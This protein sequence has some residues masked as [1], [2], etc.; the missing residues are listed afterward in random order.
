MVS[1]EKPYVAV[2]CSTSR[3]KEASL[4]RAPSDSFHRCGVLLEL[5]LALAAVKR[6]DEKLVVVASRSKLLPVEGPLQA[7]NLLSVTAELTDVTLARAQVSMKDGAVAGPCR[8]D[9][10]VPCDRA[11][12]T[13]VPVVVNQSTALVDIPNLRDTLVGSNSDQRPSSVPIHRSDSV[14]IAYLCQFLDC[15]SLR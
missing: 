13:Q 8:Q 6:R 5:M 15:S 10:F 14:I 11:H 1:I 3:G 9:V 4:V 2:G 7:A 12:S